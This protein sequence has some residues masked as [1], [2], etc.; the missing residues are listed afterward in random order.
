MGLVRTLVEYA[1][2]GCILPPCPLCYGQGGF[3]V[4]KKN[5]LKVS[6]IHIFKDKVKDLRN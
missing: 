5:W 3:S 6:E 2:Q 1:L 4:Q